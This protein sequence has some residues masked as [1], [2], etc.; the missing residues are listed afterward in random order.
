MA[1]P[2]HEVTQDDVDAAARELVA[3]PDC[4]AHAGEY[5]RNRDGSPCGQHPTRLD[6]ATLK[7]AELKASAVGAVT[8]GPGEDG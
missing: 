3:C 1:Q 6:A 7:A 5:C 4:T 8:P 2:E